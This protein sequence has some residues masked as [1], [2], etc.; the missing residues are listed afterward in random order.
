MRSLFRLLGQGRLFDMEILLGWRVNTALAYSLARLVEE[1]PLPFGGQWV[2]NWTHC[3]RQAT[4][5][6]FV[7]AI[8][9]L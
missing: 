5:Y 7:T 2:W 3:Q 8:V 1:S 9:F 4:S 6:G